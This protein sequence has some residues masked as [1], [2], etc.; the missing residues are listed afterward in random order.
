MDLKETIAHLYLKNDPWGTKS[1]YA[2]EMR[3][4]NSFNLIPPKYYSSILELGCSEGAFTKKLIDIG[5]KIYA[6]DISEIAIERAKAYC[7]EKVNFS[8]QDIR[9]LNF[10]PESFDLITCLVVIYFLPR[11]SCGEIVDNLY[12]LLKKD[13][14]ILFSEAILPGYFKYQEF[15]DLVSKRFKII[16]IEPVTTNLFKLGGVIKRIPVLSK[17]GIYELAMIITRKFPKQFVRH[18]GI[19]ATK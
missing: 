12:T 5:E 14:Y 8:V 9:N 10:E 7:G 17:T 2:E 11:I 16:K 4:K 15:I 18:L 13:G 3:L 6:V 19:L 1:V